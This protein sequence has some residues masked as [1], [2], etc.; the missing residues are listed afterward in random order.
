MSNLGMSNA[1]P[2]PATII[3]GIAR[4][5]RGRADG[6]A[7]FSGS[8]RGVVSS[9]IPLLTLPVIGFLTHPHR[10]WPNGAVDL[11]AAICAQLTCPVLSHALAQ[12]LGRSALWGRYITAFNWCQW[13]LPPVALLLSVTIGA[14]ALACGASPEQAVSAVLSV[15]LPYAL[16]LQW[17]VARH[18]LALNGPVAAA[19]VLGVN[20]VFVLIVMLA[21]PLLTAQ[22]GPSA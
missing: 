13:A 16:W 6:L 9:L 19:L 15:L 1:E 14:G 3:K 8:R 20:L 4:L 17:F 2:R 10:M 5:A 12:Y 7:C 18:A 22:T 11:L 21:P